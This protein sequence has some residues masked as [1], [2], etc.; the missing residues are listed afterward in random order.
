MK[1]YCQL[2]KLTEP[3]ARIGIVNFFISLDEFSHLEAFLGSF[4]VILHEKRPK[5][6]LSSPLL[7]KHQLVNTLS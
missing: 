2:G 3:C 5:K 6:R 7:R 1:R 4:M